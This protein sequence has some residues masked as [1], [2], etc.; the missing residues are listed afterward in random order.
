MHR[1]SET[2]AVILAG[3][4]SRR[5]GR[6]KAVLPF[7]AETMLARA[8]RSYSAVFPSV[9]LSVNQAGRFAL[10][11][12]PELVDRR[13]GQGPLAGLETAFLATDAPVVFLAAADLP[14]ADPALARRLADAC[15][16]RDACLL[17]LKEPLFGAYRRTCLPTVTELL[18]TGRRS[19]RSLLERIELQEIDP[20]ARIL[21]VNEPSDYLEAL[22]ILRRE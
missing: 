20:S 2:A 13:P 17:S 4:M 21:N 8:V 6:D 5:M 16:E 11:G 7:G 22:S 19:M 15:T 1:G 3:G 14:F 9:Y 12:V 10:P 18:D